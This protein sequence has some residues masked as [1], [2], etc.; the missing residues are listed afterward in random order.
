MF[1]PGGDIE[2]EEVIDDV[3]QESKLDGTENSAEGDH[4]MNNHR[5]GSVSKASLEDVKVKEDKKSLTRSME[6]I[7]N[8]EV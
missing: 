6:A 3:F 7:G 2:V 4:L 1:Q 5:N 8:L